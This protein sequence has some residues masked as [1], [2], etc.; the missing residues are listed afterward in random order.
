MDPEWL[1]AAN[2]AI[3]A[4]ADR[5][6]TGGSAAGNSGPLAGRGTPRS[7]MGDPWKLPPPHGEPFQRMLAAPALIQRLNWMMGS[8]YEATV[9][10]GFLSAKGS[11]GHR[12]H[13]GAAPA[14]MHN[15]YRQQNGRVYTEYVNVA[16]QLRD[17][18]RA[19]GGF[20]CVP[21]SHKTCYAV[22]DSLRECD[23]EMGLVRH[24]EMKAGD[25]LLFL[26]STQTHGAYP[27]EGEQD[28]RMVLFQ[29]R[30][31]NLHTPQSNR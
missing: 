29:Y 24:V 20:V 16:W 22:P 7:S 3:D 18:S 5:I 28:R 8:G 26:A 21:G 30:S 2:A 11:S 13:S 15:H 9:C 12:L 25:A 10:S 4:N 31:R 27:W 14:Q 19:D 17:V 1:A 6:N 23:N